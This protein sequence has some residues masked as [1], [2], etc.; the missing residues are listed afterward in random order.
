ME[1][2]EVESPAYAHLNPREI[3]SKRHNTQ[4][5]DPKKGAKAFYDLA[6]MENPPLRVVIGSDAYQAINAKLKTYTEDVKKYEELSNST[7]VEGY[8]RPS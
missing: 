8:V 4:A 7:D 1:F 5:G 3:A 6:M 2:G